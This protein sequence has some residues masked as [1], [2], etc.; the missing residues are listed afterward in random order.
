[1]IDDQVLLDKD[2]PKDFY[3]FPG[4][5]D[6]PTI[7][8]MPL[9]N[10]INCKGLVATMSHMDLHG[11]TIIS[12][13]C[14]VYALWS[15]EIPNVNVQSITFIYLYANLGCFFSPKKIKGWPIYCE[16]RVLNAE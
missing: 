10:R 14:L 13:R 12:V 6:Q 11:C 1:M 4:E 3:V 5:N 8:Y 16:M 15:R 2:W 9:F 7:I